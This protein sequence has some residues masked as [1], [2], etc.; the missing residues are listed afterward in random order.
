MTQP[1]K[2]APPTW[3]D[4]VPDHPAHKVITAAAVITAVLYFFGVLKPV[5]ESGPL[6]IPSR[7]E[8]V[9]LK[10]D[11]EGHIDT[12]NKSVEETLEVAKAANT[13]AQQAIAQTNDYRLDRLLQLKIQLEEQSSKNPG[14]ATLKASLARTNIDIAKLSATPAK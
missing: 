12:L 8:L 6:P 5:F 7:A 1:K 9:I 2:K 4:Y 13:S 11:V 14:D 10:A 3:H